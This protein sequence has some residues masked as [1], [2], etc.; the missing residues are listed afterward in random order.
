MKP[1]VLFLC[2]ALFGCEQRHRSEVYE[3]PDGFHGWAVIVWGVPSYP[4]C[5]TNQDDIIVRFPTNGIVVTSTHLEFQAVRGGSYFL[6]AADHRLVSHPDIGFAGNGFMY[7]DKSRRSMDYT[8]I[9]IG[10]KAEYHTNSDA[11]QVGQLW[12]SG[13]SSHEP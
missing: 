13:L 2:L 8:Q 11:P 3:F 6:D 10:T 4:P 7:D 5:L 12:N 9:F 1:A